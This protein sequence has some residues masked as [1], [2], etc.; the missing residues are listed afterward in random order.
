[1]HIN[2]DTHTQIGLTD[3]LLANRALF[4]RNQ[5]GGTKANAICI[6]NVYKPV[7]GV[8]RPG[9]WPNNPHKKVPWSNSNAHAIIS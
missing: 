1:M 7:P 6:R 8:N 5:H 3:V 4:L 2:T 9:K